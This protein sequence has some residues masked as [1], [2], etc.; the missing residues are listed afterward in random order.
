MLIVFPLD[1]CKREIP[2]INFDV[3]LECFVLSKLQ[4]LTTHLKLVV[5]AKMK[6]HQQDR[7]H[8]TETSPPP[9]CLFGISTS[10]V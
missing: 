8:Q 4:S 3:T 10:L 6:K 1:Y 9:P 5:G 7:K 2:E